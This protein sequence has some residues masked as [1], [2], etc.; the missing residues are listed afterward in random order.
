MIGSVWLHGSR[1]VTVKRDLGNGAFQ[2]QDSDGNVLAVDR[3][4][5]RGI[6]PV[7]ADQTATVVNEETTEILP[8]TVS[9]GTQP[10]RWEAID[11]LPDGL[12]LTAETGVIRGIANETPGDVAYTMRGY[13]NDDLYDDYELTMTFGDAPVVSYVTPQN[14]TQNSAMSNLDPSEAGSGTTTYSIDTDLGDA[15]PTG[16]SINSASG[17]ISGT[18][19][20]VESKSVVVKCESEFGVDYSTI[21]FNVVAP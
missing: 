19:T 18:P 2:V 14:L 21:V 10:I 7:I 13:V 16:L 4:R 11:A 3:L 20:V 9:R 6:Q 5:L 12:V 15:L 17:R 8:P 1:R